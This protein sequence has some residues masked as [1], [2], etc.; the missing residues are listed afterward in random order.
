MAYTSSLTDHLSCSVCCDI[1]ED[2]V[3]L[4][5]SHSFCKGCL[6]SWW[7]KKQE[8]QC[9]LCKRRSSKTEPPRNIALKNLSE[10]FQRE[11]AD[12][13]P[14]HGEKLKLFCRDDLETAC[15]IC[16]HSEKHA[17]HRFLPVDE[18]ATIH[19]VEIQKLLKPQKEKLE[20]FV[21]TNRKCE[22]IAAHINIQA[23]HTERQ[24]QKEFEKL[25]QFLEDEEESRI[26][27][28]RGEKKLKG[29]KI[30][31]EIEELSKQIKTI[32]H[33]VTETER[34]L[35]AG[36]I[37]FLKKYKATREKVAQPP[38]WPGLSYGALLDVAKHLG[39]LA[40]AVWKKL[41][42]NVS[43]YPV[44]LDP[45]TASSNLHPSEDLTSVRCGARQ[46]LPENPERLYC[47]VLGSRSIES[48]PYTWEVEVGDSA[49]WELGV[50]MG[51]YQPPG[52]Q[53][54]PM[55]STGRGVTSPL[56]KMRMA[57]KSCLVD[58]LSCSVCGDIFKDPVIL[59]CSHSFCKG[60]LQSWW[61]RNQEQQCPLCKRRSSKTEP[62]RNIAL[63][64]LSEAFQRENADLC[65][66]H[67][68]KLKLFC[69]DDLETACVICRHS[70][71]HAYHSFLPVEE[72][73]LIHREE[74]QKLMKPQKEKLN[75]FVETKGKCEVIAAHINIQAAITE[76]QIQKE[77]EKLHQLLKDEEKSRITALR[78]EEQLKGQKMIKEIEVL[79][80]QI[81][82]ISDTVTETERQ[83]GAGDISF[84]TKFK[85]TREKVA[86]WPPPSPALPK[87]A[88][89]D[90]DKHLG[91][92]AYAVWKK[93][94]ENVY[95]YSPVILGPNTAGPDLDLSEDL[96]SVRR[97]ARQQL[98]E[99][100]ERLKYGVMGSESL[101]S[102]THT[103]DGGL[104]WPESS[105]RTQ[106]PERSL[107]SGTHTQAS[108]LA[109]LLYGGK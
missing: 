9:P 49:R 5:C 23:A 50:R 98:P 90:V 22:N 31:K 82:I 92:L 104:T 60:C 25:H 59:S 85:A 15:V 109:H 24:I 53:S 68:E 16:R 35:G 42:E 76:R 100:P 45:N 29:K 18:A 84:L 80:K 7:T 101:E 12:L 37:P 3:I 78:G 65:P 13:C 61:M 86:P 40:Y 47:G 71:K 46:Q 62:P 72:A 55:S 87:G 39:N 79:S 43:Y 95:V 89:L 27:A 91:N 57:Y 94:E 106:N 41:E 54:S 32:S 52:S 38:P 75:D 107:E 56:Y 93:L 77:F 83:L 44:I 74:I 8:Q 21:E 11:N 10:A 67:G 14:L 48:G 66:L 105:L 63:K 99:N 103:R 33:T 1:F 102:G 58:D 26:T 4:S 6:Q 51:I 30:K 17:N 28:L 96:T 20:V 19:R 88:Q 73:A 36:D 64:N 108:I 2:P 97:G 69:L 70:V 34:Q 81:E